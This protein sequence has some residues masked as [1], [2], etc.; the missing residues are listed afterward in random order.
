[1]QVLTVLP[2]TAA[3]NEGERATEGNRRMVRKKAEEDD[4]IQSDELLFFPF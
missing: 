2:R 3:L 1:M 4:C